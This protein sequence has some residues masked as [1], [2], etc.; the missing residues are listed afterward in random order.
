MARGDQLAR[1]WK[2]FQ[3]LVTSRHGKSVRD[4]AK[5]LDCH[6]RTVYRDLEALEAAGFPI[7]T[8][9]S[10]GKNRWFLMDSA[11]NPMPMMRRRPRNMV[12]ARVERMNM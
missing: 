3:T 12:T 7:Y 6:K 9:N 5:N 11:R 2:I 1:Q 10:N 8:E 4:L